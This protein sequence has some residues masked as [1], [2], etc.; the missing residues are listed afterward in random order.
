[1][2]TD[3]ILHKHNLVRTSCRESI[4]DAI[5]NTGYAISE[6][7]I[8][9]RVEATYDRTTF[10]RSFKTLIESGIIHKI[11]VDNQLVKYALTEDNSISKTHVHF[12][13][14]KCGIVECLPDEEVKS[15]KLPAGYR[16]LQSELIVK[17]FCSKCNKS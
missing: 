9:S 11:V 10:Y 6:E 8:K 1:M 16:Q 2:K 12:Y 3:E 5:V 13:C 17:G 4:I 15:P 7:E 14:N